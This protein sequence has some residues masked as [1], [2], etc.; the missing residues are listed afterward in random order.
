MWPNSIH[1]PR[2]YR[3]R[4]RPNHQIMYGFHPF[5]N[6]PHYQIRSYLLG[7]TICLSWGRM[8]QWWQRYTIA[9]WLSRPRLQ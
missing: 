7:Q 8:V 9:G 6:P 4:Q 2:L 5:N 1:S 3:D